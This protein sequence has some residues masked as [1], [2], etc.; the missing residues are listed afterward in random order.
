MGKEEMPK[1]EMS[2]L[3]EG[4]IILKSFCVT[5]VPLLLF[6]ITVKYI[7]LSILML[8]VGLVVVITATYV[9]FL[10]V[11]YFWLAPNNLFFT[12]VREGTAKIVLSNQAYDR[13]IISLEGYHL[14]K[15]DYLDKNTQEAVD[16][17]PEKMT[18][19]FFRLILFGGLHWI[20]IWPFAQVY[21]YNF[22][23][24]SVDAAGNPLSHQKSMIDYV[25]CKKDTYHTDLVDAEDRDGLPITIK[26]VIVIVVISPFTALMKVDRWLDAVI[27][28]IRGE[29][30]SEITK[31]T[32]E[33]LIDRNAGLKEGSQA[34][35]GLGDEI[36]FRLNSEPDCPLESLNTNLRPAKGSD[37]E[38]IETHFG[39]KVLAIKITNIDPEKSLRDLT[40]E[41]YR[42][43]RK[44][45]AKIIT[46]KGEATAIREIA[47]A[48]SDKYV[49]ETAEAVRKSFLKSLCFSEV[50]I[51]EMDNKKFLTLRGLYPE[52][53]NN[54][55]DLV[56]TKLMVDG[57]SYFELRGSKG[58]DINS[59][60]E[61]IAVSSYFNQK[62]VFGK[63]N[64]EAE[65][66]CT[67]NVQ[68]NP[69]QP[70]SRK[71]K[72]EKPSSEQDVEFSDEVLDLLREN[73]IDPEDAI[74]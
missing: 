41:K 73:N 71:K 56:R 30:R 55:L 50:E 43:D 29:I 14:N 69:P 20:G 16:Y 70:S 33:Q 68:S 10:G 64:N 59:L 25:F 53:W 26:L 35:K 6:I 48:T 65:K 40:I 47:D 12:F 44:A 2:I 27:S 51:K 72:K 46:A 19:A 23:W 17:K 1:N 60:S 45:Q 74:L 9:L 66:N 36:F 21:R 24:T 11:V 61:M 7:S 37:L 52:D 38:Y 13:T 31:Y 32:Y 58:G 62:E 4:T 39:V 28:I 42:A 34:G 18:N 49:A 67:I 3:Q 8:A 5:L 63:N 22:S 15:R 57:K 54:A